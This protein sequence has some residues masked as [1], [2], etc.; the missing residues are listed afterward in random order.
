[1]TKKWVS[2]RNLKTREK[3]IPFYRG[4]ENMSR[5]GVSDTHPRIFEK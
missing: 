5:S 2:V 1:M 3:Y 4:N